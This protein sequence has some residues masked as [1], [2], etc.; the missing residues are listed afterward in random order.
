ME[1]ACEKMKKVLNTVPE[2]PIN[3]DSL[4]NDIDVKGT[5]KKAE[6]DALSAPLLERLVAVVQ[7]ALDNSKLELEKLFAVEI[8]GGSTR[9]Q[10][11]QNKLTE[12]FKRDISK[13]LNQEESVARGAALQCAILSPIFKVRDFS[14]TDLQPYPIRITW[15]KSKDTE[16][17]VLELFPEASTIPSS[18]ICTFFKNETLEVT[19][20]YSRPDLLPP[21]ASS[22]VSKFVVSNV[23]TKSELSKLRLKVKLDQHGILSAES[24]Q[25]VE[26]VDDN[27]TDPKA[28]DASKMDI[29]E[30]VVTSTP[31]PSDAKG[32][33]KDEG[34]KEEV[35]KKKVRRTDLPVA[36]QNLAL[37]MKTLN[38]MVELEANMASQDRLSLETAEK[39]N[40]IETYIYDMRSKLDDS[41]APFTNEED[42]QKFRKM[43]DDAE[44]WLYDEGF[45]QTKSVYVQKLDSLKVLGDPMTKRKYEA[46]HRIETANA[47]RS[48]IEQFRATATSED[49]KYD[50][51]EKS[52]KSK[53]LDECDSLEKFVNDSITKQDKLPKNVDPLF[54]VA[55]LLKRRADFERM[56]NIILSKPKPAPK[57]EEPKPTPEQKPTETSSEAPKQAETS[58]QT[59]PAPQESAKQ[60][61]LD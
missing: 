15:N 27:S 20:E 3:I 7:R 53:I 12:V 25:L 17:N 11:V 23:P 19:A 2:A 55:D 28:E 50:H 30:T 22:F 57:K 44:N 33:K 6:F 46:E 8:T 5:M 48:A 18:K 40:A 56:A 49:P 42:S 39:K 45:D 59:P 21:G 51:I 16:E 9:L 4:M 13:T 61:D 34:K 47:L 38:E 60:M 14:I 1:V 24:A 58:Q 43:L 29:D 26:N 36:E 37:P 35:K 52:E 31:P 10:A 54:T 41:L 32:D